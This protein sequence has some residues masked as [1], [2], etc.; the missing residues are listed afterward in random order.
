MKVLS[1]GGT[2]GAPHRP[3]AQP[4]ADQKPSKEERERVVMHCPGLNPM[5]GATWT[6]APK[7]LQACTAWPGSLTGVFTELVKQAAFCVKEL[8]L[9]N[10]I[11]FPSNPDTVASYL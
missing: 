3:L 5:A 1:E 8:G 11:D 7:R 6:G 9:C 4:C 2:L 10:Q